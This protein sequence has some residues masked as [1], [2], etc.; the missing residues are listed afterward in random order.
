MNRPEIPR[1]FLA[2]RSAAVTN[3]RTCSKPLAL[4]NS[5]P[6][7]PQTHGNLVKVGYRYAEDPER[8]NNFDCNRGITYSVDANTSQTFTGSFPVSSTNT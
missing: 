8:K 2:V 6:A 5:L 4:T 7:L 1:H 3:H